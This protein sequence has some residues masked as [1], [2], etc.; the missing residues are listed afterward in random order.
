[1]DFTARIDRTK[2][3]KT[4]IPLTFL[5]RCVGAGLSFIIVPLTIDYLDVELYGIWMTLLSIMS[6]I[7]YFDLGFGNGIRNKLAEAL[8]FNDTHLARTYISTGY[9]GFSFIAIAVFLMLALLYPLIS[10]GKLFNSMSVSESQLS[11]LFFVTA[12]FFLLNFIL[13]LCNNI[14]YAFQLGSLPALTQAVINFIALSAICLLMRFAPGN[15][16]YLGAC[17]GLAMAI[18]YILL[19]SFFFVRHREFI[20]NKNYVKF[21]KLNDISSLGINFFII[22]IAVLI[23]FA[24]DN[25]IITQVLGPKAV[26]PYNIVFKLFSIFTMGHGVIIASLWSAYTE[27]YVKKD[28]VWIRDV[29]KKL[30]ALMIPIIVLVCLMIFFAR[31][32]IN[33]W[34]GPEIV[35]ANPLVIFMGFFVIISIWNN[36]YTFFIN[37]IGQIKPQMYLAA[38]GAIINIPLS[39]YFTKYLGFGSSGVI[40]GTVISLSFSSFVIPIHVYFILKNFDKT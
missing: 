28:I 7:V 18:G 32:I 26:T 14:F 9:I 25:L 1:M 8:A 12:I 39:V 2:A 27:A 19:T 24:T 4:H 6:M 34:V 20:P 3:I 21:D 10:F 11:I 13:S 29:L 33:V 36:I 30:N 22:Q 35:F 5:Y 16:L 23:I 15:I 17:Y 37:G 40:L 31:K 38:F